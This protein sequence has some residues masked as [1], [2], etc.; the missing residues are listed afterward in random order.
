[1]TLIGFEGAHCKKIQSYLDSY[2]NNELLVETN[3]ELIKHLD[4]CEACARAL[5]DRVR[6]K[7]QLKR[8]VLGETAPV[9][10]HERIRQNIRGTRRFSRRFDVLTRSW[11]FAA[12]AA[13]L[14]AAIALGIMVNS[15]NRSTTSAKPLSLEAEVTPGDQTGQILKVGFEDHVYCSIDHD[16]A[17]RQF[18]KEEMS[19][20][21]GPQYEGLVAVVNEKIPR[22][23]LVVVGHRCHYKSR[24]FVHLILRK[25]N[26]IV[27][28][29]ITKKN[30]DAFP[31]GGAASIVQASGM[32]MY[33][34]EWHDLQV[35][36][37]ETRD[38]LV[39]V[40]SNESRTGNEEIASTLMPVISDFLKD[41]KA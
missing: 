3:Q 15:S 22:D 8:A 12:A 32:R 23:Y 24:D 27:S 16:M 39:Y 6:I 21:L 14:F 41:V 38:Y 36:G 29:I 13:V 37:S 33:E 34:A 5:E 28:L 10:L 35:A 11:I 7:D 2:V 18:T 1:M 4:N 17:D 20:R 26:E 40:V 30:G 25:G 19:G 31:P 9:A